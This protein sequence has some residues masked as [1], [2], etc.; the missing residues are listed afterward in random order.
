M[1][2]SI[3][4]LQNSFAYCFVLK[5]MAVAS[6]NCVSRLLKSHTYYY[7]K[8]STDVIFPSKLFRQSEKKDVVV[9]IGGEIAGAST[10]TKLV[11]L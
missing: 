5:V 2:A 11:I 8:N 10:F 3:Y 7:R 1:S 6:S 4:L 9:L